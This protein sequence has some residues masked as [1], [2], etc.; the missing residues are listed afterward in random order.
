MVVNPEEQLKKDDIQVAD[1]DGYV[2]VCYTGSVQ[3]QSCK[4]RIAKYP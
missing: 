4:L 2:E 3:D 1:R